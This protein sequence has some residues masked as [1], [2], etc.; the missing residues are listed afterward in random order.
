MA[1]HGWPDLAVKLRI[2]L[3]P[4]M[5]DIVVAKEAQGQGQQRLSLAAIMDT[6]LGKGHP[7]GEAEGEGSSDEG[8]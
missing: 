7:C 6:S 8:S 4:T 1:V 3:T 5:P 2:S